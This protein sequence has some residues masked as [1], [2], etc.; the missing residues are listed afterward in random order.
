M[1]VA[2]KFKDW[3]SIFFLLAMVSAC[4]GVPDGVRPVEDFEI[5]RYKGKWFEIARMDH[6]F[7]RGLDQVTAEYTSLSDGG[8]KV[9]N[10]GFD[11]EKNRWKV[12]E[13]KAYFVSRPDQ[14]YLKVSFFGP[15]YS[16]YVVFELDKKNYDYAFVTGYNTSYLWLLARSPDVS[17]N[18]IDQFINKSR[19]LGFDTDS[20]IFV[21]HKK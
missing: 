21:D 19:A 17:K 4:T 15:F 11:S 5:D 8:I 6:S 7:E 12:A 2:L 1:Y 3:L 13:G 10:R 16:S 14:A 18:V 20:L 9:V